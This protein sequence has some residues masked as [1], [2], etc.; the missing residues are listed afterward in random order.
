ME[1][2]PSGPE[3]SREALE[4]LKSPEQVFDSSKEVAEK[5]YQD[6]LE[7]LNRGEIRRE[8]DHA[9]FEVH[10][11]DRHV[12]GDIHVAWPGHEGDFAILRLNPI[13]E[14]KGF[15][16]GVFGYRGQYGIG[17]KDKNQYQFTGTPRSL[18]QLFDAPAGV[19]F[20]VKPTM[21]RFAVEM[22]DKL[23]QA[24]HGENAVT[25]YMGMGF[26]LLGQEW[27]HVGMHEAGHLPRDKDG[28]F[29]WQGK[30]NS[31][32]TAWT[33]ANQAYAQAHVSR[34]RKII[35]GTT[36]GRFDLL[37]TPISTP[38]GNTPS[39]G[40]IAQYGLT[41]HARTGGAQLPGQWS[42]RVA[43]DTMRE[44]KGIIMAA[45]EAYEYYIGR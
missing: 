27:M 19:Q 36:H 7:R 21:D 44:F 12:P 22:G 42:G 15:E 9:S 2:G 4:L 31:E 18:E 11:G 13:T 29:D 1:R 20:I 38:Y 37:K 43:E 25:L 16:S 23:T 40:R 17:K 32:N 35:A 14:G 3:L 5:E 10:E 28:H 30:P 33:I 34:K 41:S 45:D 6:L 8:G 24:A 39:L 26:L